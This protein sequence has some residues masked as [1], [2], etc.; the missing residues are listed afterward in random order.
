MGEVG[1]ALY[2]KGRLR[3][4]KAERRIKEVEKKNEGET[5]EGERNWG[6]LMK[7]EERKRGKKERRAPDK[8]LEHLQRGWDRREGQG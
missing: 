4:G 5:R 6:K 8:E 7:G 2:V 1:A 3:S